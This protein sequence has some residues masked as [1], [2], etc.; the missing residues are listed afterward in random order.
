M[1]KVGAMSHEGFFADSAF[2]MIQKPITEVAKCGICRLHTKCKSP[3]M[4]PSGKGK[5]GIL[6]V[7]EAP[8]K[9]E[10]DRG[11]QFVGKA[12]RELQKHLRSVGL[13]MREDCWLENSLRCHPKN[14]FIQDRRAIGYCQPNVMNTIRRYDPS[15]ILLLGGVA[16]ESV[17]G[18]LWKEGTGGINRWAGFKIPCRNPNAWVVPTFHPSY[19]MRQEGARDERLFI[20][21]FQ[22]HLKMA[23]HLTGTRPWPDGVPDY[24]SQIEVVIDG[25]KAGKIIRN[26]LSKGGTFAWD[27][28]TDRLKPEQEDSRIISC[29]ICWN[30]KRTISF[31]WYGDAVEAMK[32][33]LVS[34]H[35]KIGWNVSY[36]NKWVRRKLGIRVQNWIWDGMLASH[37]L[38]CRPR[39]S[40]LKF[41]AFVRRGQE[42]YDGNIKPYMKAKK[43]IAK[44]M[45]A[46][47]P[48]R[49]DEVELRTLLF[50]GGLDSLHTYHIG[51]EQM[52]EMGHA[53]K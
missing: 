7:G 30:G 8:G 25:N 49:I 29:S 26:L 47:S 12:G 46:N 28:E 37:V 22:R 15:V 20:K 18:H 17:I 1:V 19:I 34:K 38:D 2:A 11:R 42:D 50:Y 51:Q 21:F 14:N 13:E 3:K 24:K 16:V 33:L 23:A 5:K 41:Q 45:G 44:L 27:I 31:P 40:S 6:I 48:N 9:D 52:E 36:E 4:E 35:P 32:E 10:D 53:A 43:R 39:I